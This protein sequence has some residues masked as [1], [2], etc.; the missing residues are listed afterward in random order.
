MAVSPQRHT[1]NGYIEFLVSD[2]PTPFA[3]RY[4][5]SFDQVKTISVHFLDT[6]GKSDAVSWCE[7]EPGAIREDL[8]GRR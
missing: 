8:R 6:G 1:K 2:T 4:I 5:L 7:F 3:A